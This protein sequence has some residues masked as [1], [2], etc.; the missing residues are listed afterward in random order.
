[1]PNITPRA[2]S[3]ADANN[4]AASGLDPVLARIYAARGI[5]EMRQ[6]EHEL[7]ALLPFAAY[8]LSSPPGD[9]KSES[10]CGAMENAE[11][12]ARLLADA[13]QAGKRLLIVADYDSDGATA[14]AVAIRALREF[15]ATVDYLV[16]NRFEYGYGLT[17][18]IV[19]LAANRSL[20]SPPDGEARLPP[21]PSGERIE[22]RGKPDILITVDNGISSVAG[23]E[24]ARRLGMEVL[25]TDHHLPGDELPDAACIVNP[26]QLGCG[27]PSKNLAGVGVI[28][29]V[30]LA[31]RTELRNRGT[32][33]TQPEPNL[34]RLLD[35]VALG[36][37]AD[38]V[39]LDDNNRI[40]VHQGLKR[41][42]AGRACPGINA[43][44]KVA[45]RKPE[46]ASTYD[47]G[48]V[49]GPRL[50]AAGRLDDMALGIECLLAENEEQ[51]F[52]MAQQLD[53]LN[54]ERREIEADMQEQ[55]LAALEQVE[56][57]ENH[58]LCLYD[59]NWHQGVIGILAS[60]LKDKYHRPVIAFARSNNGELK[61]SGRS[62]RGLHLRDALDLVAKRK[63]HLLQK[64]GGHAFAA[65]LTIQECHFEE[66]T[67]T[68][69]E[70]AQSLLAPADLERIIESDGSL[71][72]PAMNL[73]LTKALTEQVWGQGFPQPAFQ[74]RFAVKNQRVVG[75]K[76]L[77]LKL[78]KTGQVF[79]GI[80]F[81]H[82]EPLPDWINAVYRLDVNEYNGSQSLQLMIEYWEEASAG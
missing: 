75:E 8:D 49:V 44:L 4:L 42:R 26:N 79:D 16:P 59:P 41:I 3:T 34:A 76:H 31:L 70:I 13:I 50:N 39:K 66:F 37:V 40:L 21:R 62:I 57:S 19:Q 24:E 77:R 17:P 63:P 80:L 65:G 53:A 2:Y 43:I 55:A 7:S 18:E 74:E 45:S 36:T 33:T 25:V 68:F 58:S 56:V 47:L 78:G 29:Y 5:R 23:V 6:L 22:E 48:F 67:A 35:L 12:M 82:N 10:P 27:F 14:C 30:M 69:E 32:Y 38:V 81:F 11:E 28:F 9:R 60:R 71:E 1:M 73:N 51:A 15:G 54:R 20:A 72:T 61:G 64:F 52:A 46:K